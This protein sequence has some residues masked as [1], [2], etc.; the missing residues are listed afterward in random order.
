MVAAAA[1]P[2]MSVNSPRRSMQ[3]IGFAPEEV[4]NLRIDD[5]AIVNSVC[6]REKPYFGARRLPD[7]VSFPLALRGCPNIGQGPPPRNLPLSKS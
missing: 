4:A 1:A 5:Y 6:I 2:N 7:R 3:F